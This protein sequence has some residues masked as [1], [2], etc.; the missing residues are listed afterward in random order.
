VTPDHRAI[1]ELLAGYALRSLSGPDADDAEVALVD[2]VP[3]CGSCRALLRDLGEVT[4]DLALATDP[5]PPP[6]TLLPRLHRSLGTRAGGGRATAWS[7]GR[8]VA[9]AA[10]IVLVVGLGG[11][12]LRANDPVGLRRGTAADL[13]EALRLAQDG[14]ARATNL[15]HATEVVVPGS[16]EFYVVGRDVPAPPTGSVYRLWL[17]QG[18]DAV[19]VGDFTPAVDGSVVLLVR[20]DPS[21]FDRILVTV[22]PRTQEPSEP[23][24]A[25]DD[26]AA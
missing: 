14:G 5:I 26:E 24:E 1:E 10:G 25:W 16:D 13:Q 3:G 17:V 21:T 9:A 6:E 22:E 20:A 2:H 11:L 7:P 15:G 12:A 8:L 4:A 23:G 18:A 19:H